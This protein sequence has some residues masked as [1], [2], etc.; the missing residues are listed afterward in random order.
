[1]RNALCIASILGLFVL[2]AEP[3]PAAPA[4]T[5]AILGCT[6]WVSVGPGSAR[7][8]VYRSHALDVRNEAITR[9]LVMV[10]GQGRNADGYFRTAVAAALLA[11]ALDNTVVVS[12]RF[13]SSEG[14]C[15][16]TLASQELN[17]VCL[18]P[19]SWRNGGGAVGNPAVTSFDMGDAIVLRLAR[20][21]V[22]PNIRLIVVAGHSA[23]GQYAGRY[24]MSN[25]LHDRASVPVT[26]VVA[27]PSSY[28]YP[29]NLR[30][31]ISSLPTH[32]AALAPGYTAPRP[33]KP[34][35]S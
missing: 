10:H 18:G 27:N 30:P 31:T 3:A 22:F 16:D 8:L 33:A 26:Y 13:A 12:P 34:P 32:V 20:K 14:T 2:A 7:G 29:D 15:R 11:G 24:A 25:Q 9:A 35:A 19:D 6:E 23:G 1:M 17:W 5:S 21:E 4:C 28:T